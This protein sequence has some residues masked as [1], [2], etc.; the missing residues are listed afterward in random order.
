MA[1]SQGKTA[2]FELSMAG[3][4]T[5]VNEA[6]CA[7][8][9]LQ[10]R[11]DEFLDHV[12]AFL[13]QVQALTADQKRAMALFK[14]AELVNALLQIR[15]RR[16]AEDRFGAELAKASFDRNRSMDLGAQGVVDLRDP[17][18]RA[19][20]DEGCRLFHAGKRDPALYQR[21]LALSASQCIVLN[22][23]LEAALMGYASGC[24]LVLPKA[25]L[26]AVREDFIAPY[27]LV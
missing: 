12:A 10:N 20:I 1:S 6:W 24:G 3:E 23:S 19:L 2:S 27:R 4:M 8:E 7:L 14:A 16:Q 15:E 22:P 11:S 21:A 9:P 17:P 13:P 18:I 26:Q 25:L 5:K